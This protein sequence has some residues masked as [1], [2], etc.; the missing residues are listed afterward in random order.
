[1]LKKLES[2]PVSLVSWILYILFAFIDTLRISYLNRNSD[3][4]ITIL[5]FCLASIFSFEV[6][7]TCIVK[8]RKYFL[9]FYFFADV[10][11]IAS[12]L[13]AT[14]AQTLISFI[15]FSFL[16]TVMVIR[17]TR[18]LKALKLHSRKTMVLNFL[19][20]QAAAVMEDQATEESKNTEGEERKDD[21]VEENHSSVNDNDLKGKDANL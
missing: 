6:L 11:S 17:V 20:H 9:G 3:W 16:K 10:L 15:V 12:A 1:M 21:D 18:I 7:L 5:V 13:L 8:G 2:R 4:T 14:T 19:K